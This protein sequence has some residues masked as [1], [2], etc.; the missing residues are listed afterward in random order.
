MG[1]T[2]TKTMHHWKK[3]EAPKCMNVVPSVGFGSTYSIDFD[4]DGEIC[5]WYEEEHVY[6]SWS[7][8]T[9]HGKRPCAGQ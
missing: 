7:K 9:P 3:I 2:K 1:T 5:G 4:S 8:L 6:I